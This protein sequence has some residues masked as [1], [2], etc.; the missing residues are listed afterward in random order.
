MV[1]RS[2]WLKKIQEAW[3]RKNIVWL[4]GV[5]RSGKTFIAQ[6]I[7]EIEYFDC[8]LKRNRNLIEPDPEAFWKSF[9]NKRN[10]VLDEIHRLENPSEALKIAADHFPLLKILATGSSTLSASKKFKDTLTNRKAVIRLTPMIIEDLEDFENLDLEHRFLNG[11]LPP[12]FLQKDFPEWDFQ[13]WIDSFW[14]K[15]I[16]ELF[17]VRNKF[18]FEKFIERL[19]LQSGGMF[20]ANSFTAA[21]E[22]SRP[23]V[24]NYLKILESTFLL[25]VLKPFSGRKA[26]EIVSAPKVYFFDTG[27][28]NY[29]HGRLSLRADDRGILWEHF[30]LNQL[31]AILQDYPIN[32]WRNKSKQEIDFVIK[33][34]G[35]NPIAIETKWDSSNFDPKNLL[36]FRKLHPEG[37]NYLISSNIKKP[38]S[39]KFGNLEVVFCGIKDLDREFF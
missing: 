26:R 35:E 19:A 37:R 24:L 20:E 34:R 25:T 21:C 28:I 16:Q 12:F 27:L 2:Y 3:K 17:K 6:S 5:R 7:E 33:K 4:S 38:I 32:Y 30:V 8:E 22:V 31:R 29:F 11:G 18:S 1:K 39:R 15:D 36:A 23:T 9:G 14:A 13:E 10:I